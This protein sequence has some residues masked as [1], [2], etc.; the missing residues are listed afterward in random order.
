MQEKIGYIALDYERELDKANESDA[1]EVS[2]ELIDGTAITVGSERFRCPELL[3]KPGCFG[4][5]FAG[6]HTMTFESIMLLGC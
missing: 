6:I 1:I 5:E 4:L 3:F 2:H